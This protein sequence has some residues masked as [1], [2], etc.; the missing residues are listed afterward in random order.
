MQ[1]KITIP[2]ISGDWCSY[3]TGT[4]SLHS[5]SN[6]HIRTFIHDRQWQLMSFIPKMFVLDVAHI[7]APN[8]KVNDSLALTCV[9]A[10]PVSTYAL[11]PGQTGHILTHNYTWFKDTHLDGICFLGGA[12]NYISILMPRLPNQTKSISSISHE[13][14]DVSRWGWNGWKETWIPQRITFLYH[15]KTQSVPCLHLRIDSVLSVY[16]SHSWHFWL[17]YLCRKD[18]YKM[19]WSDFLN[20]QFSQQCRERLLWCHFFHF[21][22]WAVL[23]GVRFFHSFHLKTVNK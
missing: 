2:C 3:M 16:I 1:K 12:T 19:H 18:P 6:T 20:P 13:D 22:G 8:A 9:V 14:T 4:W 17:T 21:W 10:F 23:S 7:D 5:Q 11:R 15:P